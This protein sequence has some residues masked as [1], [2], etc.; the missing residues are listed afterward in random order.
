VSRVELVPLSLAEARRFVAEH[1]R[2]NE[3][4]VGHKFSIG[5]SNGALRGVVIAGRP[6]G[7]GNDDGRTIELLRVTTLS[8]GDNACT[9]LYGAA[10]RAAKA[11]GYRRAV[12]YTLEE[13]SGVSLRAAGFRLD[14]TTKGGDWTPTDRL[15]RS[16]QKPTLFD[17]PKMPN[18]PKGRWIRD[19]VA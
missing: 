5:L 19:L 18:G 10:C 16:A 12:T 2:H 8:D 9:R 11:M 4:P 1:H 3:P 17:A 15:L 6:V 7:R 13:E 14:G